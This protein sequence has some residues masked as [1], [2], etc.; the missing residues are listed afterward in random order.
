MARYQGEPGQSVAFG[1]LD[2]QTHR[3]EADAKGVF[4]PHNSEEQQVL[5][6]FGLELI[7]EPKAK[8]DKPAPAPAPE[9]DEEPAP[10][11]EKAED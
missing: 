11:P 6:R 8:P 7:D 5:A 3:L 4:E 2:G 10:E 9:Q 1:G